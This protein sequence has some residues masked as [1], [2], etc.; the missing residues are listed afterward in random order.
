MSVLETIRFHLREGV[1]DEDFLGRNQTVE[2][3]YMAKRPGFSARWTS[4]SATG[5]W[6]VVVRWNS[7]A[8][9]EATINE[10]LKAPQTQEFLAVVDPSTVSLGHYEL[11]ED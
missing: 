6:L 1:S 11:V 8:E 3:E 4:K 5:E 2:R 9:A 10:F 7:V